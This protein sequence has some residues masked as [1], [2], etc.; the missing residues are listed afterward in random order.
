MD[1]DGH[2]I[3]VSGCNSETKFRDLLGRAVALGCDGHRDR[4]LRTAGSA[5]AP[6]GC[7]CSC[8]VRI[9]RRTSPTSSGAS[10]PETLP[11]LHF[12]LGTGSGRARYGSG[13]GNSRSRRPTSPNPRRSASFPVGHYRSFLETRLPP[14][15]AALTPGPLITRRGE[16]VGAAPRLRRLPPSDSGRDSVE[17]SASPSTF[18][19]SGPGPGRSWSGRRE[20]ALL[21]PHE[22]RG[23]ETGSSPTRP[24]RGGVSAYRSATRAPDVPAVLLSVGGGQPRTRVRDAPAECEPRT[25]RRVLRWTRAAR[26]RAHL[27]IGAQESRLS[28]TEPR[29]LGQTPASASSPPPGASREPSPPPPRSDRPACRC[30]A[31][32]WPRIRNFVPVCVAGGIRRTAW[33]SIVFTR[34]FEPRTA[35]ARLI[36]T[37]TQTSSPSRPEEVV[38][39]DPEDQDEIPGFAAGDAALSP[40]GDLL[41]RTALGARGDGDPELPLLAYRATPPA[42][43]AGHLRNRA[44]PDAGRTGPVDGESPLAEGDDT[45]PGRI[46]RRA[47]TALPARAPDPEQVAHSSVTG[48]VTVILP[49]RGGLP[50]GE[51]DGGL[52]LSRPFRDSAPPCRRRRSKIEVKISPS[53]PRSSKEKPS[54][55]S[56][57]PPVPDAPPGPAPRIEGPESPHPVV[58]FP[59]L[60]VREY[61]VRPR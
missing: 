54:L 8:A 7:R 18:S 9:G 61:A 1:A 60:V 48:T 38:R 24:A 53:P 22:R 45:A 16:V 19:R 6:T 21:E 59:F 20:G 12:P 17:D 13:P 56:A 37:R 10:R 55:P 5:G 15:H 58:L 14:G 25:V 4:P 29:R 57:R 26:R 34:I 36:W 23:A 28:V 41:P 47:R 52:R 35:C 31:R 27:R 2:R 3:R 33:P 51:V 49:P 40:A 42:G 11:R 39:P 32:P 46:L 50:E 44:P 30:G 43:E